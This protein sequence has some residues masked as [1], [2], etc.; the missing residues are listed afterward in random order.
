MTPQPY[1]FVKT[2]RLIH[3]IIKKI[4]TFQSTMAYNF[5]QHFNKNVDITDINRTFDKI[6]KDQIVLLFKI[7]KRKR[8]LEK[9]NYV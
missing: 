3:V 1:L 4:Y 2:C 8:K 9:D 5:I 7:I 6:V